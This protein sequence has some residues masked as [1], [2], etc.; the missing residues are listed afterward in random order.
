MSAVVVA[1]AARAVVLSALALIVVACTP[2]APTTPPTAAPAA[3][4]PTTA[5]AAAPAGAAAAGT[6]SCAEFASQGAGGAPIKIGSDG[7]LTG[8]TANFGNGM[9]RGIEICAKEFND[10]GGYQGRKVDITV[11]DDHILL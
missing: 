9:K 2:S 5:A 11:L 4:K 3:P 1:R 6:V 10:A 8:P 7:S